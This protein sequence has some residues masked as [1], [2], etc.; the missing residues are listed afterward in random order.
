MPLPSQKAI[1][2]G[3][4]PF[5]MVAPNGARRTRKDHPALP[6]TMEQIVESA[7]HCHAAGADGLHLHVR[8]ATGRHSLDA[9]RYRETLSELD[10]AVPGLI[11]QITTEA[12]GIFDV[13]EQLACLEAVAPAWASVSVREMARSPELTARVY[14]TCADQGTRVQHI[15]YDVDDIAM[16]QEW[17]ACGVVHHDQTEMIFVLGRY[18]AG[19]V[20][21]PSD[22]LPFLD[23]RPREASWM[24]CAFGPSEHSC[25]IEAARQGGSVRVGFENSLTDED[26]TPWA[27]NA[28][29][30]AALRRALR[31]IQDPS[32]AAKQEPVSPL[33][34]GG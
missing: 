24:A 5:I 20:S 3:A 4:A 31:P 30:V 17:Q 7:R 6:V 1:S 27:D 16:L 29:S 15:L 13:A 23:A 8:D 28:A 26:G 18:A 34:I 32:S 12:G 2:A 14:A 25:L 9:G 33:P 22:L 11:V 10:S 19:Q 21:S